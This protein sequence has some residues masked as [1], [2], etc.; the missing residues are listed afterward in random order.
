MIDPIHLLTYVVRPVLQDLLL[1]SPE[2]ERL[3]LGTACQES[4]C[5]RYL[6]QLGNVKGGGLGIYQM[7]EKS[8]KDHWINYLQHKP[9]LAAKVCHW[10]VCVP[11]EVP[12]AT[13]MIG[14]L[15]FATAMC[16]IHYLRVAEPIPNELTK[17]AR[18]WKSA[19]NTKLGKGTPE[20]YI[21]N[22][23]RFVPGDLPWTAQV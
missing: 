5:G 10:S 2:A 9:V 20:Q 16:R 4:E 12:D 3:V 21:S 19:Y 17:Q 6:V 8:Y 18:Y 13:E 14:N 1:W 11:P 23:R 15:N 22:W 7:E